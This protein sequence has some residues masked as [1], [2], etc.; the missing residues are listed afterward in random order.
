[1]YQPT[2][3][4]FLSRDPISENGVDVLTDTG[5]Y[6]DR[7][8]AMSANPSLYGGNWMHP[9][10]YAYNNPVRLGDPSGLQ[11]EGPPVYKSKTYACPDQ[12]G[13][14]GC[15]DVCSKVISMFN[16]PAMKPG[17]DRGL[18]RVLSGQ[19]GGT[20][21]CF[22][23][24][25]CRCI[26][27]YDF[28]FIVDRKTYVLV[29]TDC[30]DLDACGCVHEQTHH[31][32]PIA[33]C[34]PTAIWNAAAYPD[35]KQTLAGECAAARAE[36]ACLKKI[37]PGKLVGKCKSYYDPLLKNRLAYEQHTCGGNT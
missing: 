29:P 13:Q 10:M 37:P 12:N 7:L 25:A 21:V 4:R 9:Y 2:L 26:C 36:I 33:K 1:M 5:F 3:G 18:S 6:S 30:P 15:S 11:P 34:A 14:K 23:N 35:E 31:K 22:G 27:L 28:K 19:R 16:D 24:G 8:A 20:V 17:I 32:D